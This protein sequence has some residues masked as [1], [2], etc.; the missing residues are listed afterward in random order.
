MEQSNKF[1][2]V[3]ESLDAV[4]RQQEIMLRDMQRARTTGGMNNANTTISSRS[5]GFEADFAET[6]RESQGRSV[7]FNNIPPAAPKPLGEAERFFSPQAQQF[8][9]KASSFVDRPATETN[10]FARQTKQQ[11]AYDND[12]FGRQTTAET[13]NFVWPREQAVEQFVP[14]TNNV[15]QNFPAGQDPF[16]YPSNQELSGFAREQQDPFSINISSKT[17]EKEPVITDRQ[18]R[19]LNRKHLLMMIR[20]LEKELQQIKKEKDELLLAYRAGFARNAQTY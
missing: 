11:F 8:V 5:A 18:L 9:P 6:L 13:N 7:S 14:K 17:P 16:R 15:R 12:G 4:I 20:D 2:G 3:L 1:G 10:N 19:A